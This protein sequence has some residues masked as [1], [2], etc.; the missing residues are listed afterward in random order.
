MSGRNEP[1]APSC[2]FP[3]PA[4]GAGRYQEKR[5]NSDASNN[6]GI[7]SLRNSNEFDT[8]FIGVAT[9]INIRDEC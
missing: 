6:S 9:M 7:L 4:G 8:R 5:R 2:G 3:N 1:K